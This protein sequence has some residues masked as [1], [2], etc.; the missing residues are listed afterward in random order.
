MPLPDN[1]QLNTKFV[2]AVEEY[3]T[4]YNYNLKKY[5]NRNEQ[6]KVWRLLAELFETT[7]SEVK[8]RWRNIRSAFTRFLRSKN[9]TGG[10]AKK[11][12]YLWDHLQFLLP[13]TKS[14][15]QSGNLGGVSGSSSS[16]VLA[17]TQEED[18]DDIG[19]NIDEQPVEDTTTSA[20]DILAQ[21][22]PQAPSSTP[23]SS[24][25]SWRSTKAQIKNLTLWKRQLP[26]TLKIKEKPNRLTPQQLL[27]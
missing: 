3:P 22:Q 26:T 20:E 1:E 24:L 21:S 6:D 14:R 11:P 23:S 4:M 17:I 18:A 12:Y 16:Q 8:L 2:I 15:T 9:I 19:L 13:Y 27:I 7:Q 25:S 10:A 5:S